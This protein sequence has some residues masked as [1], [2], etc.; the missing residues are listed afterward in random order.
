MTYCDKSILSPDCGRPEC[1]SCGLHREPE[2]KDVLEAEFDEKFE[3]YWRGQSI[4]DEIKF[5]IKTHFIPRAEVVEKLKGM[6][7]LVY[8]E[9]SPEADLSIYNKAID[10]LLDLLTQGK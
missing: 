6:K 2:K 1:E 9:F 5:F 4:P 7:F 3:G 10:D 8:D